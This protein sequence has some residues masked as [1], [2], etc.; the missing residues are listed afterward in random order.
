MQSYLYEDTR[1]FMRAYK[2]DPY[3]EIMKN[4]L[5][6]DEIEEEKPK[7]K[8]SIWMTPF[9]KKTIKQDINNS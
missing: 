5:N 6:F 2:N 3:E 9:S 4:K 8:S 7:R 1:K